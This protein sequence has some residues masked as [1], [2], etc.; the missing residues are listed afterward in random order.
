MMKKLGVED[1]KQLSKVVKD[2]R[3]WMK[4]APP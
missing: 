1:E 3:G 4:A 2:K